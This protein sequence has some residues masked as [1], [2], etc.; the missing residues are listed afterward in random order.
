LDAQSPVRLRSARGASASSYAAERE[1][2]FRQ[3]LAESGADV[4]YFTPDKW[5]LRSAGD[6]RTASRRAARR[7]LA[8]LHDLPKPIAVFT[9]YDPVALDLVHKCR[10]AGVRVPE[11]VA[12]LGVHNGQIA[13]EMSD[14]P[15]SSIDTASEHRGYLAAQLL[16]RQF[17]GRVDP[18][19]TIVIPPVG[20]V[21]R[22]STEVIAAADPLVAEALRYIRANLARG[23]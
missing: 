4:L 6:D 14:P 16:L 13:C 21:S 10:L 19:E 5:R 11:D 17:E 9:A 2:G 20:I 8:W 15:L 22:T 1:R 3:R 18:G 7:Q 23:I 12:V